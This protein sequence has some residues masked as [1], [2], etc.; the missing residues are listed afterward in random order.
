MAQNEQVLGDTLQL[1][2]WEALPDFGLYMDQV[3]VLMERALVGV[4]PPGELTKSMV[5][6]YVKVGLIPR[7]AGKKY[8]REH[9]AMLLMICILKQALSMEE[10]AA[11]LRTLC[12]GGV[13]NGYGQFLAEVEALRVAAVSGRIDLWL[14]RAD[15]AR[16]ALR[17]GVVA[18][19][20]TIVAREMIQRTSR[21][22]GTNR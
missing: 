7:P 12:A 18:A 15:N 3:I 8:E 13:H 11:L 2:A 19:L 16:Q 9:L 22:M 4:L 17:A 20:C 1:P 21:E 5:N 14:D 10:I 6:N